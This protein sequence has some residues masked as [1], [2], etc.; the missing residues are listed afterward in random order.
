KKDFEWGEKEDPKTIFL[1]GFRKTIKI[2][3]TL[4]NLPRGEHKLKAI[5]IRTGDLFGWVK[6]E[7]IFPV[8]STLPVYPRVK[9]VN[10]F[11]LDGAAEEG[12]PATRSRDIGNDVSG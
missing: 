5:R 8:E 10:E 2:P 11:R 1:F 7:S 3:Y 12:N 6:K 9:K 4:S